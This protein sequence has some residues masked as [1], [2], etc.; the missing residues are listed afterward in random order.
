M[1]PSL[2]HPNFRVLGPASATADT[3]LLG[4]YLK[5]SSASEPSLPGVG[6]RP[7]PKP[8]SRPLGRKA[9]PDVGH[10]MR[11]KWRPPSASSPFGLCSGH[12]VLGGLDS[13]DSL[14]GQCNVRRILMQGRNIYPKGTFAQLKTRKET[15]P[16]SSDNS[17][18]LL[19]K[20]TLIVCTVNGYKT[21]IERF[22]RKLVIASPPLLRC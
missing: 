22:H 7:P 2:S 4:R 18:A 19:L 16:T 6:R 5:Q 1:Q 12:A 8:W 21:Q 13:S 15:R 3:I 17:A 9:F 11:N 20:T 14:E 10:A